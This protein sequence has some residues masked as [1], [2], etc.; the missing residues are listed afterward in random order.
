MEDAM[1][2]NKSAY[3]RGFGHGCVYKT[4]VIELNETNMSGQ[5]RSKNKLLSQMP[6][7]LMKTF[8]I[9]AHLDNDGLPKI[10]TLLKKGL[11]EFCYY[12]PVKNN[13]RNHY[14][15]DTE[16]AYVDHIA[17][18]SNETNI[19][20]VKISLKLRYT[21]NPVIGDKFSSRHGQKG[22]LSVLWP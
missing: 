4:V 16:P 6:K 21:R 11:A 9:Q 13:I 17:I 14:Y 1:I 2:I 10:G 5:P 19:N 15:K 3:E 7:N 20:D 12:D 22:V 8:N 18:I